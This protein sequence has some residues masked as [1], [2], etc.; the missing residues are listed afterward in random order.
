MVKA[1]SAAE[2]L[3]GATRDTTNI[4]EID[5]NGDGT[6]ETETTPGL[7]EKNKVV[8]PVLK[9]KLDIKPDTLNLSQLPEKSITAYIELPADASPREIDINSILLFG[10]IKP[11]ENSADF[12]DLDGNGII[13]LAVKFDLQS[14]AD[15]LTSAKLTRGDIAFNITFTL[16]GQTYMVKD[17]VAVS[18]ILPGQSNN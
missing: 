7:F 8:R 6:F 12:T 9:A 5:S 16:N 13:E 18:G 17:I 14:I 2:V 3:G 11:Q 15:Y 1:P 10:K 4:L